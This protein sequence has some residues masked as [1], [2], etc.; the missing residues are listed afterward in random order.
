MQEFYKEK[1]GVS[2]QSFSNDLVFSSYLTLGSYL[3]H[4]LPFVRFPKVDPFCFQEQP[5]LGI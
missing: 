3:G 4:H 5:Q 2:G 1:G